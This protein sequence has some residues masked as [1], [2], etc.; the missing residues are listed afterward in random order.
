MN[1]ITEF[2]ASLFNAFRLK[3]PTLA[4]IIVLVLG[5]ITTTASQ[6]DV[7]GLFH[8]SGIVK[9]IVTYVSLF[10]TAVVSGG[11]AAQASK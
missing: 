2:F 9:E 7:L 4:G 8:L 6:G 11:N 3:N 1:T 5:A 10:L